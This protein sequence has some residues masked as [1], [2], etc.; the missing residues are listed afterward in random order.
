MN[1][2][3]LTKSVVAL[4]EDLHSFNLLNQR[5]VDLIGINF[6][7]NANELCKEWGITYDL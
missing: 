2:E 3:E 1:K 4:L 7:V 5:V 6:G